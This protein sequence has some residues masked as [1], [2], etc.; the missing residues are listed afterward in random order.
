MKLNGT[1]L[2]VVGQEGITEMNLTML[3]TAVQGGLKL[4][5]TPVFTTSAEA[6]DELRR[7]Q[8]VYAG[9]QTLQRL[10]LEDLE[11]LV[12]QLEK[13]ALDRSVERTMEKVLG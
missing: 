5:E 2:F 6:V 8:L 13:D 9:V 10:A 11:V 4:G 1:T 7:R 12:P 3:T